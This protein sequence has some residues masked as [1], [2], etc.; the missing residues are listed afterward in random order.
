MHARTRALPVKEL[1][2]SSSRYFFMK[3]AVHIVI[4]LIA[5]IVGL[6][7]LYVPVADVAAQRR[8]PAPRQQSRPKA[9]DYSKFSHSTKKHQA[10]CNTCHKVPTPTWQKTKSHPDITDYPGHAACVSCHRPQFFKGA[11]PPICTVCHTR[12][13]PREDARLAFRN[14]ANRL[15][16]T[17]EFP[18]DKHQDVIASRRDGTK[19][20][21]GYVFMRASFRDRTVDE[22]GQS[23]NN[24]SI[25]HAQQTVAPKPP[26]GSWTDGFIPETSSFKSAPTNHSA[27][28]NCHWKSQQPIAENCGGCHT[29]AATASVVGNSP[30]RIS[31]KFKHE[32]GGEKKNHLAECTTC[33]I[34]I[35]KAE[36]LRGLKPDVP[37]T[38]CTECHNKEGLRQDVSKE[39]VAID[40]N[41]TFVCVY[42]HTSNV[43]KLDPP[44]S[45]YL[46]AER[47]SLR[48]KDIK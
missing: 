21:S 38:S 43:G 10:A 22:P 37:I 40:K 42:C 1:S 25:C 17:I 47:P 23:Y 36:S 13:S 12:V 2:E 39:L 33:H 29:L 15:Q 48:R 24:C 9:I 34:N 28:F 11:R 31:L 16:F 44:S 18:H 41:S 4:G 45:H 7:F 3:C 5:S 30:V 19:F 35:T 27:C 6:V 26:D 46:I 20:N 8:R 14:P 32:G